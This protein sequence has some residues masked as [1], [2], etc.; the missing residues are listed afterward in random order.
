M[1]RRVLPVMIALLLFALFI[2]FAGPYFAFADYRPFESRLVRLI[3]ILLVVVGWVIW[4]LVTRLR[5]WRA[6]D[7]LVA[8]VV[9][10]AAA[11]PRPSADVVQ[12]RERFEE[13]TAVLKARKRGESS[14][15]DLPWYVIIGAPGSGKTTA[16]INSGLHFPLEQRTGRNALRGIGGTRN[17]DWWFTD[18]AVLLDTAGRYTTQD[19]D[20]SADSSSWREFLALLRKYRGR[21]PI[22][23]VILAISA[24]DLMASAPGSPDP[25]AEAARRR[26]NE[27]NAELRVQLPVYVLVTK[28]DLVAGFTDYFEDLSQ[29]E[30]AQVWGVTFPI[31]QTTSGA[32]VGA[33]P[34]EFDALMRRL[35]ERVYAR[36]EQTR[37]V[38]RRRRIF[39]FPQQI[40][41]LREQLTH[42]VGE[43]FA[44]TRFDQQV[45]LRGVY[46]TSGT[47]EG[48]PI[49]RLLGAMGRRLG[50][51]D[52][53]AP[54]PGRGKSYFI[55]R[56]LKD[57]MFAES[58]L[59]GVNRRVEMRLAAAQLGAYAAVIVVTV[60][61][62]VLWSVSFTRNR[63]YVKAVAA[64]VATLSTL[65]PAP[66]GS[67]DSAL[68]RL[69]RIRAVMESADRFPDGAPWSMRW[70]LFQGPGLTDAARQA[71]AREL[72]GALLS[73][74]AER[75][76]QRLNDY[77]AEPERLYP[78]LKAYLM[79]GDPA[80]LDKKQLEYLADLEWQA[81]YAGDPDR[82]AS[83]SRHF[84]SLLDYNDSL[85]PIPI[86]QQIVAQARNTLR[87]ASMAGLLYRYVR[88]N[89]AN[90]TAR[91]LR[92]DIAAGLNA[93][94]VLRRRG[95]PLSE[96][97]P[98]LYTKPVF[99]EITA[100]GTDELV[101]QFT[102]E[103]WVWGDARPSIAAPSK[104]TAELLDLYEKD[105][106]SVWDTVIADI[107]AAPLR[108]L[109]D[110]KEALAVLAGPVSPLR[111]LL[112]TIDEHTFLVPPPDPAK[113]GVGSGIRMQVEGLFN[114]GREKAGIVTVV[115][116]AQIT[117]HFEAI[118]RL[119]TAGAGGAPI[120]NVLQKLQQLQ[121]KLEPIGGN[122]G[123]TNPGDPAAIAAVGQSASDL[124]R[125][126]GPLPRGIASVV[127]AVANDA[128]AAVRGGVRSTLDGRYQQEVVTPCEEIVN[129]RYPFVASS[130]QQIPLEDFGRLLGYGGVFDNFFKS[131]LSDLVDTTRSPWAWRTDATG[132]SVGGSRAML[133]Q[134]ERA[135]RIRERFF[136]Q[137]SMEPEA[138]FQVSTV[139]LDVNTSRFVLDIHGQP[140]EYR[141]GPVIPKAVTWPGTRPGASVAFEERTGGARPNRAEDGAWGLFRLLD[142]A[143]V[144]RDSDT[145]FT[146][147]FDQGGRQ[148]RVRIEASS[149]RNPFGQQQLLQQF[150]CR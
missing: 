98:S 50:A 138:R 31:E 148:A 40:A 136:R 27:L 120:D 29:D 146:V 82:A 26:L 8:A 63:N 38:Q 119:V 55:E 88:I 15:Y 128:T 99:Q 21:R 103:Y 67:V 83:V 13:A 113:P 127:T 47:Q 71:Y 5:A 7:K 66:M 36:V 4:L 58:G 79:L 1:L 137:G 107:E 130:P 74:V 118:H 25:H 35:N 73:Q 102:D 129:N 76:R 97:I 56:L 92:L 14:L 32:A 111:G 96:P 16:L 132:T 6:S 105:Y 53:A 150:R 81:A 10:Q 61:A 109:N 54:A 2:W 117:A 23:G 108:S 57:V 65:P 70:G 90:D 101:K 131:E 41:A 28:C 125:E 78:Y 39:G 60:L 124:K 91:A 44:S 115:P 93:D 116:G 143:A 30:R 77:A 46:F 110:T 122:V 123:G 3:T 48:T 33:L 85:R 51:P 42:Y 9:Q 144:Q 24:Q 133:D 64:D 45:L 135:Q 22:N 75:F 11:E 68:P 80:H 87:Q 49:D 145:V 59:A 141:H 134:F 86:D 140:I 100:K 20:A 62:L 84:T 139:Y 126:A 19:S 18:E 52:V 114:A 89:Y 142:G 104:L 37:D 149:V 69:D 17:C 72:R 106:I 95:R 147:T 112:K 94:R 34:A 43:V 121:Q 12:L